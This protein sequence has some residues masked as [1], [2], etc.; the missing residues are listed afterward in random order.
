METPKE[1][2]RPIVEQIK[3]YAETRIKL[4]KYEII[5]RST[6]V[7]AAIVIDIVVV[8][9]LLLTF[10]FAS[11][12]LALFLADVF[13]SY[14]KGFGTVALIYL[15]IVLLCIYAKKSFERPIINALIKKVFN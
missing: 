9:S 2:A 10:L 3:E 8:I 14:W 7:I 15:V 12:T 13:H 5:D 4:A 6:T 11:I 1:T